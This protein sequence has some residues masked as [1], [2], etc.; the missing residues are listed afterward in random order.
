MKG[1]ASSCRFWYNVRAM[2]KLES[3]KIAETLKG[4][5]EAGRWKAGE[6]LPSVAELRERFGVGE[7]AVRH[8]LQNLRDDGCISLK[9]G[10][11]AVAA[12]IVS[13]VWKGRIALVLTNTSGSYFYQV[14]AIRLAY[15]FTKA[16][17]DFTTI[18]VARSGGGDFDMTQLRRCVSNGLDFAILVT[19][20]TKVA[21]VCDA[22]DIPYIVLNGYTR[23]F[24]NAR[25]VVKED[26]SKCFS[27]LVCVFRARGVKRVLEIDVERAIDRSFRIILNQAGIS[28][29][30]VFC[31]LEG[32]EVHSLDEVRRG[33]YA[34]ICDFFSDEIHRRHLPDAII[35]DDDYLASGGINALLELGF[36]I[37]GD[38]KIVTYSNSGNVPVV[39]VPFARIE[40]NPASYADAVSKYVLKLLA[41]GHPAPPRIRWHFIPGKSL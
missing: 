35:F 19:E 23:N 40:N 39:G 22:V 20:E 10:I 5:L 27:D 12:D 26:F 38:I 4:E 11:G 34:G 21:E 16:G 31:R 14:L 28:V 15:G 17:W 24:P 3:E 41:G 30:R 2:R 36:T 37:P 6:R 18:Y 13:R 7:W 1:C 32:E 33:G 25:A 9:Q 8:A 29:Q